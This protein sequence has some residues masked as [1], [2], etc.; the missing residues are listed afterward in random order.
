TPDWDV[1]AT[2]ASPQFLCDVFTVNPEQQRAKGD[3]D[4]RDLTSRLGAI[5]IGV[6]LMIE[7]DPAVSYDPKQNA[8]TARNVERWLRGGVSKGARTSIGGFTFSVIATSSKFTHVQ[9]I[10]PVT[11]FWGDDD[12]LVR[13]IEEKVSKYRGAGLPIVI[14]IFADFLTAVGLEEVE[15]AIRGNGHGSGVFS[16]EALSAILWISRVNGSWTIRAFSNPGARHPVA[17]ELFVVG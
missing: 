2:T 6:A 13:T 16:N 8:S 4:L 9:F 1:P 17:P 3:A 7:R 15:R 14:A 12:P 11:S 10:A 5:P